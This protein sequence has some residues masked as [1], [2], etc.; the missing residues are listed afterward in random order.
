MVVL[1]FQGASC[2]ETSAL[3]CSRWLKKKEIQSTIED[4]AI[5]S[6]RMFTAPSLFSHFSNG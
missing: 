5:Y 6:A 4:E 1:E 2:L 3:Q